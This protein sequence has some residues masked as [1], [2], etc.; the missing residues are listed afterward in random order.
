MRI[1]LTAESYVGDTSNANFTVANPSLVLLSPNGGEQWIVGTQHTLL[2][3]RAG[4]SENVRVE[5]KRNYPSGSWETVVSSVS[6]SAYVWTVSGTG[7]P[8]ARIRVVSTTN[9]VM[10]DT[11]DANFSIISSPSGIERTRWRGSCQ[12]RISVY[13]SLDAC[14]RAGRSAGRTQP[15]LAIRIMG[16]FGRNHGGFFGVE[17]DRSGYD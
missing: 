5:L 15:Q 13:D 4:V 9:P 3:Q 14:E 7:G 2:W 1:F 11:C 17:R 10:V 16:V 8:N 12:Y 6:G